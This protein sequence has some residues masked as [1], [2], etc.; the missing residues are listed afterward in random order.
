MERRSLVLCAVCVLFLAVVSPAGAQSAAVIIYAEGDS[1]AVIGAG[2]R[3]R[4]V[5]AADAVGLEL[6][7]GDTVAT[8]HETFVELQL[9][10]SDSVV[11][12]AENTNFTI[13]RRD[14]PRGGTFNLVYGKVRA[15]VAVLTNREEFVIRS[16]SAIAGVRG[17]D[18]GVSVVI[19]GREAAAIPAATELAAT[20]AVTQ[21]YCF[22]GHVEV[23]ATPPP[24]AA[25]AAPALEPIVVR[26]NEVV[27]VSADAAEPLVVEALPEEIRT[28]WEAN[29][30]RAEPLPGPT[31]ELETEP[32]RVVEPGIQTGSAEGS[33]ATAETTAE[34]TAEATAEATAEVTAET[35]AS[36]QLV[37]R[38]E[39]V[40]RATVSRFQF[41]AISA[42]LFIVGAAFEVAGITDAVVPGVDL[43][44]DNGVGMIGV[45]AVF[46]AGGVF[47]TLQAARLD[48]RVQDLSSGAP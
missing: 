9:T 12:I 37:P 16:E 43:F 48:R 18:F 30:F 22:D 46:V 28:Y 26:E 47:S 10:P 38:E 33:E 19:P 17:T 27:T 21:V 14:T 6:Q 42:L 35:T 39:L 1:L 36:P 2:G 31:G 4:V 23:A 40:R 34:V 11:K 7:I 25:A 13:E 20:P 8:E 45:G 41:R 32:D 5:D 44:G 24:T 15:R 29:D 3:Q